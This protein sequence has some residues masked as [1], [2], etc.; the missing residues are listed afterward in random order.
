MNSSPAPSRVKTKHR[1]GF[2]ESYAFCLFRI[3]KHGGRVIW[4]VTN[5]CNYNCCYCIFSSTFKKPKGELETRH[6]MRTLDALK[7]RGFTHLK[8]TGGEPFV[9]K[10]M[11][12]ILQYAHGLGFETD[13]SSNASSITQNIAEGLVAAGVT[14]VH[15]SLDGHTLELQEN[16]RGNNT[17][18]RTIRGIK[19]LVANGLYTRIG[20][21]LYKDNDRFIPEMAAFCA[22]LGVNEVIFSYLEAV[23]RLHGDTSL[24]SRRS[25]EELISQIVPLQQAYGRLKISYSFT[26]DAPKSGCGTCPGATKFLSIDY[27][28]RISPCTWVAER[29][30]QFISKKTLKDATLDELLESDEIR[31]YTAMAGRLNEAG[32]NRCPMTDVHAVEEAQRIEQFFAASRASAFADSPKFGPHA[33]L[34]AFSTENISGYFPQLALQGKNVLTVG[35]SGDHLINARLL[36]A[37][38]VTCFDLNEFAP[39]L[40]E[41]KRQALL[42]LSYGDFCR[43]FLSEDGSAFDHDIYRRLR[44][45]L[46]LATRYFFDR[47]YETNGGDG[48]RLRRSPIFRTTHEH[49]DRVLKNNPYLLSPNAFGEAKKLQGDSAPAWITADIRDLQQALSKT[50]ETFDLMLLSNIADYAHH[51]FANEPYLERFRDAIIAPLLNRLSDRGSIVLSYVYDMDNRHGSDQRSKLNGLAERRRAFGGIP[52]TRY[53]ETRFPSVIDELTTDG[54]AVLRKGA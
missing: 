18:D 20:C 22:D 21:L 38:N 39:L 10:D 46:S 19:L 11:L 51:M 16:V 29:Q 41:L 15:V 49:T 8:V 35:G 25:M 50:D 30:P 54:V 36:G 1:A 27:L 28:G 12:E 40:F 9:R 44:E 37:G 6:V 43:F 5:Q 13:I 24:I 32:M 34:Y 47:A 17:F 14:T 31:S 53:E 3:P 26:E 7:T 4:Q 23:G 33:Q 52:G 42:H 48:A 45:R 2:D